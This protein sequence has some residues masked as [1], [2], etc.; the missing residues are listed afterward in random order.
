MIGTRNEHQS[1]GSYLQHPSSK[2]RLTKRQDQRRLANYKINKGLVH[3]R[4]LTKDELNLFIH[5]IEK[6]NTSRFGIV[7]LSGLEL[8]D[9]YINPKRPND[10]T[11]ASTIIR[12]AAKLSRDAIVSSPLHMLSP[13]CG[14]RGTGRRRLQFFDPKLRDI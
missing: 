14:S 11:S 1:E 12:L 3:R 7:R 6:N 8:D 2:A 5:D 13:I 4:K 10:I 9:F